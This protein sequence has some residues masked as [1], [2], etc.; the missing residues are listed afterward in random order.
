VNESV[1]LVNSIHPYLGEGQ[2]L[3][4]RL[5]MPKTVSGVNSVHPDLSR[6][7][8]DLITE[9]KLQQTGQ[10][11]ACSPKKAANPCYVVIF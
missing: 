6:G 2:R 9:N 3:F 10:N 11:T 1:N 5:V 8:G 4:T 7:C